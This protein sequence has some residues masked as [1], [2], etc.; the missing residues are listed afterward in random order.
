M[1]SS[2][3]VRATTSSRA[4]RGK[5]RIYGE[6]GNDVL[7]GGP[8]KD[9]LDGGAGRNACYPAAGGDK[10][11]NCDEA[12]LAVDITIVKPSVEP[13]LGDDE[14]DAVADDGEA[15]EFTVR[16]RNLGAKRSGPFDLAL[17]QLGTGIICAVDH[18]G[19][20]TEESLWPGAFFETAYAIEDGCTRAAGRPTS[21]PSSPSR[22]RS[23]RPTL[24]RIR[25]TTRPRCASTSG[26]R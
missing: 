8:G 18:S 23:R 5:D 10:L 3:P 20:T 22:R 4:D 6:G 15:I 9:F 11:R 21:A 14:V 17:S 1:T 12:D 25:T 19:T 26:L 2:V 24:T 13:I 16:V 7:K